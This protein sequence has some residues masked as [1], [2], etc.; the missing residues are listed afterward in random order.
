MNAESDKTRKME[1]SVN[2]ASL[3]TK[4]SQFLT[5]KENQ[6]PVSVPQ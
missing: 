2:H 4:P 3:E 5:E 1:S 6:S